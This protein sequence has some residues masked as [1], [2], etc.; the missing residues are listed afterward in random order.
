MTATTPRHPSWRFAA[1]GVVNT[2]V[3][4]AFIY[5]ARA[6]GLGEVS[7]NATGYAIGVVLSFGLNRR[8]TFGDRGPLM[9]N[10]LKFSALLLVAWLAN[11]AALLGLMRFGMAAAL[12][13]AVAV[14]TYALVSYLGCRWWVFASRLSS[15]EDSFT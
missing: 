11:L 1:V 15:M 10:A 14:L 13:Q 6:L 3:G 7:A 9:P 8:W 5:S 12:A 4:L 2:V